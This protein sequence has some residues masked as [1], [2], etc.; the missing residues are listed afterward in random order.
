MGKKKYYVVWEG[1]NPGIYGDWAE[2][3]LQVVGYAGAKY[4]SF[5]S[6]AAAH[7]AYAAGY[8]AN[9]PQRDVS[10]CPYILD[11]LAVDA[12]CSGNPGP[13]EYRGVHIATGREWFRVGPFDDGTNNV[14][15]F[16]ALVHGLALMKRDNIDLPIY[17]DSRNAIKW[18]QIGQCRTRLAHTTKNAPLFDLIARAERWLSLN[19]WRTAI[20]KWD[21]AAWGEIP[22]DFGRK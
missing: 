6:L 1:L 9:P 19:T 18:V 7:E 12:A 22:A 11:S 20:M 8:G 2:C 21:T 15:E 13:V 4:K 5:D 14:G 17:S 10:S 16:L 3:K